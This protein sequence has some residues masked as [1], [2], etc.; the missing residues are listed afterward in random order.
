MKPLQTVAFAYNRQK[1]AEF[2]AETLE[3]AR[4][5]GGLLLTASGEIT[6]QDTA[7]LESLLSHKPH[8]HVTI[9]KGDDMVVDHAFDVTFFTLEPDMLAV[10]LG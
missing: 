7:L 4:Q 6:F 5:D 8:C 3:F 1:I 2:A 10:L 9:V